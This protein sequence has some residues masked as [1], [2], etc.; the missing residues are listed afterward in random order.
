[1]AKLT[2]KEK[3]NWYT[4]HIPNTSRLHRMKVDIVNFS[5]NNTITHEMAKSLGAFQLMLYGEITMNKAIRDALR[6]LEK[7]SKRDKKDY[8]RI[9]TEG[10]ENS[11][12]LKRDLYDLTTGE[13]YEYETQKSR[14]DRHP[15]S[16]NVVD[17][18]SKK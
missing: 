10:E 17:L 6:V 4:Y 7:E 11:T 2:K 8:H 9:I 14:G 12:R 13:I 3:E 5:R 15:S 1:M 16:I 18:W